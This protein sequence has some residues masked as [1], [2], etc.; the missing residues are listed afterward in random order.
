MTV[1]KAH[2][3]SDHQFKS[4][5]RWP[6]DVE[7]AVAELVE[8]YSL[9]ICCGLS[10]LGDVR[11]DASKDPSGLLS[12]DDGADDEDLNNA[13]A[14]SEHVAQPTMVADMKRL[15]FDDCTFDT[16]IF[17]PPWKLAYFDRFKPFYEAVRVCRVGG[18]IVVNAKWPCE[19]ELTEIV[20]PWATEGDDEIML[21]RADN[22]WRDASIVTVHE[23]IARESG[24]AVLSDWQGTETDAVPTRPRPNR[25]ASCYSCGT[26]R[27]R[28]ELGFT[29]AQ[30]DVDHRFCSAGCLHEFEDWL[31]VELTPVD[32]DEADTSHVHPVLAGQW[33][34]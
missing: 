8:G 32:P 21:V 10:P 3:P 4:K 25:W 1:S 2:I 17:D 16:V 14:S 11:V 24:D 13:L 15:P 7:S 30:P 23:K 27:P 6:D 31:G 33:R 20:S 9:N 5:W 29:S 19:S 28:D 34:E 22:A 12:G 18:R 26:D